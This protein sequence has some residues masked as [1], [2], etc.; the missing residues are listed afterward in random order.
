MSFGKLL[1][2][3]FIFGVG[4]GFFVQRAG[5]C[6]SQGLASIMAGRAKRI[7]TIFF[8]IF[9][10]TTIGFYFGGF[11]PVGQLRGYGFFNVLS[12][13]IFGI[14]ISLAGGCILGT[15][16]QI[17]EG[18]LFY[19]IVFLSFIPGMAL[20]IKFVDPF[21]KDAYNTKAILLGDIL[22]IP[23][24]AIAAILVLFSLVCLYLI[25]KK[26]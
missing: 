25:G 22:K 16:R 24:G 17:G 6:F 1:L 23:N 7:M 3:G 15:L 26:K 18:N 9:I 8:I 14:G 4:F 13:I 5:I 19:L 10:I 11:K 21:L 12:G 20:V 2:V